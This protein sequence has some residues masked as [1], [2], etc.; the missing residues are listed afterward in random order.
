MGSLS[1]AEKCLINKDDLLFYIALRRDSMLVFLCCTEDIEVHN[2]IHMLWKNQNV[3]IN[4]SNWDIEFR[5]KLVILFKG[6]CFF[7]FYFI[8][9]MNN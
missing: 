3:N 1:H 4:T 9:E 2:V 7:L 5:S 6:W 8:A